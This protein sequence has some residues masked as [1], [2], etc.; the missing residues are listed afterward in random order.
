MKVIEVAE[1]MEEGG[2]HPHTSD[3]TGPKMAGAV[4]ALH[5]RDHCS[6]QE[7]KCI[8]VDGRQPSP[9]GSRYGE[10]NAEPSGLLQEIREC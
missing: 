6:R 4:Q 7:R 8:G 2:N 5:C 9:H 3:M 10:C 1:V